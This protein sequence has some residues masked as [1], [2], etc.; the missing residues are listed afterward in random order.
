MSGLL[1]RLPLMDEKTGLR[2]G[3][4]RWPDGKP[5][6]ISG[7]RWCGATPGDI[8]PDGVECQA[9]EPPTETQRI[10][11]TKA[12]ARAGLLDYTRR[13]LGVAT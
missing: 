3:P 9:Y 12:H 11:R 7:C 6:P 2:H 10:A 13:E 1:H 4:I 5:P 8:P